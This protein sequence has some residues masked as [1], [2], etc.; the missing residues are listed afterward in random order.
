LKK[1]KY[2]FRI[3]DVEEPEWNLKLHT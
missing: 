1:Q 3:E 2:Q